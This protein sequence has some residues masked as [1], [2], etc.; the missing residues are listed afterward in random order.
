MAHFGSFRVLIQPIFTHM[1]IL[2]IKGLG[3]SYTFKRWPKLSK[4]CT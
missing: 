1:S 4:N 2:S 3:G